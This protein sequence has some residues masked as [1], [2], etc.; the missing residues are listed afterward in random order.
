MRKKIHL[1]E[2]GIWRWMRERWR[3]RER[4]TETMSS[5]IFSYPAPLCSKIEKAK[6]EKAKIR[7]VQAK[8]PAGEK[9]LQPRCRWNSLSL[10]GTTYPISGRPML[11]PRLQ[12]LA[13]RVLPIWGSREYRLFE[14]WKFCTP[15]CPICPCTFLQNPFYSLLGAQCFVGSNWAEVI[16]TLVNWNP[17]QAQDPPGGGKVFSGGPAPRGQAKTIMLGKKP[18]PGL[19]N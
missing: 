15:V 7:W 18:T 10:N 11:R 8:P 17:I 2:L 5:P 4:E 19:T 13:T 6:I 9:T 14:N 1:Y 12:Y 16:W 3:E